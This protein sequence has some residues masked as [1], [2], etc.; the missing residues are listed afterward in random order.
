MKKTNLKNAVKA[1]VFVS[2]ILFSN[3]PIFIFFYSLIKIIIALV[4]AAT[5]LLSKNIID[6]LFDVYN[7]ADSAIVWQYIIILFVLTLCSSLLNEMGMTIIYFMRDKNEKFLVAIIADKLSKIPLKHLEN[8]GSLQIIHRVIQS[9]FSI[10]GA[11]DNIFSNI[12]TPVIT[13]VSTISIIF[14]YYP[15]IALAY[16]VTVIPSVLINQKQNEKM[17]QHSIDSIPETRKKDYQYEIL[18]QAHY[19]KELRL[20]NLS[21]PMKKRFN[22]LWNKIISEREKIFKR[23]FKSLNFS[24]IIN[25][26]GYVGMYIYLIYKTYVGDLSIGGLS[27][28]TAATMT[29]SGNFSMM[30]MCVLN[31]QRIYVDL[32]LAVMEFF[33]W[34]NENDGKGENLQAEN[35][36]ITFDSV[37]FTYPNTENTVLKNLSFTIKE[38]E[39]IAIVGV[40]GAGKS[41][42]VKLLLRLYEPDEGKILINGAN[43]KDYDINSYRKKFSACF[44]DITRYSLTLAENVALSD[45]DKIKNS[46]AVIGSINA[47]GL[48]NIHETFEKKLDAPLTRDFDEDGAELSGGQ[49]QKVAIAR[50][51][52]R[53]A[54]FIILDE[55]SSALDPKAESQIFN[56]FSDLCGNKS[57]LLISHRLSSIMLVDKIVFLEDGQIKEA[58]THIELMKQNGTYAQ[59]YTLQAEKY[60]SETDGGVA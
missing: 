56:S 41:T 57:G 19:A 53:N 27:A 54:P 52:F 23:G 55:P 24:S 33:S 21:K 35:F 59:M 34:E 25:C 10:T 26:I 15:L 17:N 20:Y 49:W 31:Y 13:F 32:V 6:G 3:T 11:F 51:F 29:I 48:D 7:G 44:Q 36:E 8:Q 4:P 12:I 1:S 50:A 37:S 40:N 42:I 22:D 18:T 2:K 39:K 58:G 30:M 38:G 47:S 45:L 46:D 14:A 60:K 28:F 43:I 5:I 16:L 9:Q